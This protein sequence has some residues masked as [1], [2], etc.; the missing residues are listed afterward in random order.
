MVNVSGDLGYVVVETETNSDCDA[1]LKELRQ[2]DGTIRARLV[3]LV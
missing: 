2:L 3:R 1:V